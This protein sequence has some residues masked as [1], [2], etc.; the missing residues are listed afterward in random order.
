MRETEKRHSALA[1]ESSVVKF[2]N[3]SES[4]A[5]G[6]RVKRGVTELPSL[7]LVLLR[8]E[9]NRH[10]VELLQN[11][12]VLICG[13]VFLA[14]CGE[15]AHRQQQCFHCIDIEALFCWYWRKF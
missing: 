11:L 2:R 9:I 14:L 13:T 10:G 1:A 5:A 8:R 4:K 3:V 6:P 15:S 7:L 12:A